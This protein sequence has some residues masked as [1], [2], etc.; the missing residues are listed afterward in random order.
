MT[1][2][3]K[4]D[5]ISDVVCPWCIVG[6]QHLQAAIDE[7]GL[8]NRI[9]IE[10]QPFELNPD[11][12][13]EGEE[14]REHVARKYGSSKEESDRAREQISQAGAKYGF[15][16]RY[17]DGMKI[18]NTLDA[19]VL[20]EYAHTV[21]KQTE[22]KLRLF[23]AFF[24][25]QKDVSDPRVLVEE[26][27]AVGLPKLEVEQQ[28]SERHLKDKIR[29]QESQW[30]QMGVSSVPTVVFNRTS[31]LTGAHP[32]DTYKQVLLELVSEVDG[33]V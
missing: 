31:A 10:W 7:L 11:M 12:P 3:I 25:E 9:E 21:G 18:V 1:D 33:T 27:V 4:L 13:P 8:Q 32:Q 20:L 28:L 29:Q 14:L 16:F 24:T 30:H 6:Y 5:I 19:H 15:E 26:A 22:L 23:S 17:F 2:K